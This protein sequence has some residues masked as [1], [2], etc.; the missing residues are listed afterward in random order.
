MR[1]PR[2]IYADF[3]DR[4]QARREL[5]RFKG[6]LNARASSLAVQITLSGAL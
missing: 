5:Q 6:L 3:L 1:R 4:L 2:Q